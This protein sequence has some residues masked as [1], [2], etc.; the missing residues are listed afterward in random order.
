MLIRRPWELCFNRRKWEVPQLESS[1][2][3]VL[4]GGSK[5][6]SRKG[7]VSTGC[8]PRHCSGVTL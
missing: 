2:I 7:E 5:G 6:G 4:L 1:R 3:R 8:R